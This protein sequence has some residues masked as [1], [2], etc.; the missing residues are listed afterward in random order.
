MFL[1]SVIEKARLARATQILLAN[2][3]P[4]VFVTPQGN[5]TSG[6]PL[7][8]SQL[9]TIIKEAVPP[10]VLLGLRQ[11]DITHVVETDT[12]VWRLSVGLIKDPAGVFI[13]LTPVER[14]KQ[15]RN[16]SHEFPAPSEPSQP[17]KQASAEPVAAEV[18]ELAT[19]EHLG[20]VYVQDGFLR[21]QS[22]QFLVEMGLE[23]KIGTD[24][25]NVVAALKYTGYDVIVLG[26]ELGFWDDPVCRF[27]RELPMDRRRKVLVIGLSEDGATDDGMLAFSLSLNVVVNRKDIARLADITMRTR[28]IWVKRTENFHA[29]LEKLGKL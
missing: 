3:Q 23:P 9:K 29:R 22:K 17:V 14:P 6:R 19:G 10:D 16:G 2:D 4:V 20:L 13:K 11:G 27:V 5:I 18:D 12:D 26:P 21:A 24:S 8:T 25:T 1:H 7:N 15:K 28:E